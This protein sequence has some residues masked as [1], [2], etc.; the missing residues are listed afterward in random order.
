MRISKNHYNQYSLVP[1]ALLS[2]ITYLVLA[3]C[4]LSLIACS[5]PAKKPRKKPD[6]KHIFSEAPK[7][8]RTIKRRLN[9]EDTIKAISDL[10]NAQSALEKGDIDQATDL[11][12]NQS[13]NVSLL[14]IS[15]QV[16]WWRTK[17]DL[18]YKR[19]DIEENI[20]AEQQMH[21][22]Q[23]APQRRTRI[24]TIFNR[25]LKVDRFSLNQLAKSM[26]DNAY[27][28]DWLSLTLTAT[29]M[30]ATIQG[31]KTSINSWQRRHKN[32]PVSKSL[33]AAIS[34]FL[35][36]NEAPKKIALL[37][38]ASGPLAVYGKAIE[39]G[40]F[41]MQKG[42]GIQAQ[43]YD[44][45]DTNSLN[46]AMIDMKQNGVDAVVGPIDKQLARQ[47]WNSNSFPNILTLNYITPTPNKASNHA[48]FGIGVEDEARFL[49]QVT[50][51]NK[52]KNVL[53][54]YEK[55]RKGYRAFNAFKEKMAIGHYEPLP[56]ANTKELAQGISKSVN[57]SPA[58]IKQYRRDLKAY[59]NKVKKN[60]E[61]KAV[62]PTTKILEKNKIDS[63]VVFASQLNASQIKSLLDFYYAFNTTVLASS[64]AYKLEENGM[65]GEEYEGMFISDVPVL[66]KPYNSWHGLISKTPKNF[67][68][69]FTRFYALGIDAAIAI[70]N[71]YRLLIA[72]G[73]QIK[74]ATGNLSY[75]Q[76]KQII[77]RSPDLY[78]VHRGNLIQ[79][80]NHS[81]KCSEEQRLCL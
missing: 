20:L 62:S 30:P 53:V 63:A 75:D 43:V 55:N 72:P 77:T 12:K 66:G 25:L 81:A 74:G 68:S 78:F 19:G 33:P 59:E 1:P 65:L 24:D 44:V 50:S 3:I 34:Q 61:T 17:S 26:K 9:N 8:S 29:N 79:A 49:A 40:F 21:P 13:A 22:L 28:R 48:Q 14:P 51:Y 45:Y 35:S 15:K 16:E 32:N 5:A 46:K 57:V 58:D 18:A 60:P 80:N 6:D 56:F 31:Q 11:L 37:L 54:A 41:S 52:K 67:N 27:A 7:K 69:K 76:S 73:I 42:L 10:N 23:T 2:Y 4:F 38:P 70:S 39:E 47:L 64:S 71:F 36:T